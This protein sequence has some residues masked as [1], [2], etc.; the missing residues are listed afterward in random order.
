MCLASVDVTYSHTL[1]LQC[2]AV[3]T[4]ALL[5]CP[6]LLVS[7]MHEMSGLLIFSNI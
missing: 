3:H 5:F 6:A 2:I 4:G 7:F 1:L